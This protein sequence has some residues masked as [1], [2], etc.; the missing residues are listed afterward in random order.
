MQATINLPLSTDVRSALEDI[1]RKEGVRAEELINEAIR[2][3]LFFRRLKL[4]RERLSAIAQ[5]MGIS[6]EDD[7]FKLVTRESCSIQ[8]S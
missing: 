2:E 8:T 5:G 7:V 6:N 4:L 1:T 3:Y